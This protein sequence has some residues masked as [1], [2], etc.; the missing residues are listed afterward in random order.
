MIIVRG[1]NIYP[2]DV[3]YAVETALVDLLR[4]GCSGS[5]SRDQDGEETVAYVAE[6]R[7]L[8]KDQDVLR[9]AADKVRQTVAKEFQV[10]E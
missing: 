5:F 8:V 6:L 10:S 3:E 2:Q 1:R 7:N 4:P 9:D